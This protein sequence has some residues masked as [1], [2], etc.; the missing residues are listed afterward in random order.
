MEIIEKQIS[1]GLIC[2]TPDLVYMENN[3][4]MVVDFKT[5]KNV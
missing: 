1:D 4:A 5:W 3:N 2:G